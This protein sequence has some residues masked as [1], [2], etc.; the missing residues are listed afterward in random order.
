MDENT[1]NKISSARGGRGTTGEPAEIRE[2]IAEAR[3]EAVRI[4]HDLAKLKNDKDALLFTIADLRVKEKQSVDMGLSSD[5][6]AIRKELAIALEKIDKINGVIHDT[7]TPE[8]HKKIQKIVSDWYGEK[9]DWG[10]EKARFQKAE[11][12]L[13]S[14]PGDRR[15]QGNANRARAEMQIVNERLGNIAKQAEDVLKSASA[16]ATEEGVSFTHEQALQERA[17]LE[18]RHMKS[19]PETS[20]TV[21][22]EETE[23]EEAPII[24]QK[25]VA[26]EVVEPEQEPTSVAPEEVPLIFQEE[27]KAP[28]IKFL[29]DPETDDDLL[30]IVTEHA[31][32]P[33]SPKHVSRSL[34]GGFIKKILTFFSSITAKPEVHPKDMATNAQELV[35]TKEE[36]SPQGMKEATPEEIVSSDEFLEKPLFTEFETSEQPIVNIVEKSEQPEETPVVAE[37]EP[38]P[39]ET[40]PVISVPQEILP[41]E[42]EEAPIEEYVA[43]MPQEITPGDTTV[44]THIEAQADE[45]LRNDMDEIFGEK[46]GPLGI[47][48][49]TN[50]M[51]SKNWKDSQLGFGVKTVGD[52]LRA[53]PPQPTAE[54]QTSF[55]IEN[56]DL[57]DKMKKYLTNVSQVSGLSLEANEGSLLAD[58][59][60]RSAIAKL[61]K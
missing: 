38:A 4:D 56:N 18:D 50:G 45:V 53:N 14:N 24:A 7:N 30:P 35:V 23:E 2:S 25:E 36:P 31:E 54:G 10:K 15:A 59:I 8:D 33:I 49:H 48:G 40:A 12:T 34:F 1:N 28:E 9:R 47:L 11:K 44:F 17:I 41:V 22:A 61:S 3:K 20:P 39:E 43:P 27:E 52:V 32:A 46:K 29:P 19:Q 21:V 57:V 37:T 58:F 16:S 42:A 6:V 55:G 51:E 26:E 13:E 60:R 5:T